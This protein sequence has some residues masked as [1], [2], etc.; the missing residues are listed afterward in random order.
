MIPSLSISNLE[1]SNGRAEFHEERPF[2]FRVSDKNDGECF[3]D[4]NDD[5][6]ITY[7]A[8][9]S[10]PTIPH[11]LKNIES[12]DYHD[13]SGLRYTFHPVEGLAEENPKTPLAKDVMMVNSMRSSC[14]TTINKKPSNY[15]LPTSR[16]RENDNENTAVEVADCKLLNPPS[17]GRSRRCF[18]CKSL[19][20]SSWKRFP[21]YMAMVQQISPIQGTSIQGTSVSGQNWSDYVC[22]ACYNY[23]KANGKRRGLECGKK[24]QSRRKRLPAVIGLEDKVFTIAQEKLCTGNDA[25]IEAIYSRSNGT[26][27]E[28]LL[29]I[30]Q[31]NPSYTID[32]PPV[33]HVNVCFLC[34]SRQS[35][36]F[37]HLNVTSKNNDLVYRIVACNACGCAIL[38]SASV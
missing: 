19:S 29:K 6:P 35:P 23:F 26:L 9:D 3:P 14:T 7:E 33:P 38:K 2:C 17:D 8:A 27:R 37:R 30:V 11:L 1:C 20:A 22:H 4:F 16:A 12:Q 18:E 15:I 10:N 28:D 24:V 36:Q 25:S 21:T 31:G 5:N 34:Q 13:G 32:P